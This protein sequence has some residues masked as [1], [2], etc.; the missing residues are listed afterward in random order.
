M[1]KFTT[2][3]TKTLIIAYESQKYSNTKQL[4]FKFS[5]GKRKIVQNKRKNKEKHKEI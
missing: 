2:L 3:S 1:H 5:L 4:I